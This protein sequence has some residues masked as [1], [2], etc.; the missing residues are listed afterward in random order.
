MIAS[1]VT[2]PEVSMPCITIFYIFMQASWQVATNNVPFS[3]GHCRRTLKVFGK[4]D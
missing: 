2:G 4:H 1:V 3:V